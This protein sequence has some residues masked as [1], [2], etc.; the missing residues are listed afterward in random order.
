M[1]KYDIARMNFAGGVL[2]SV[3]VALI[4][5]HRNKD[6]TTLMINGFPAG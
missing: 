4:V 2:F 3:L 5:V 6:Q 1:R